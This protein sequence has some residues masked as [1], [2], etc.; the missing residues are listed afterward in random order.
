MQ[1]D[2]E[3]FYNTLTSVVQRE[4]DYGPIPFSS[5]LGIELEETLTCQ[6]TDQ[7]PAITRK[8]SVNKLVCNIR[9]ASGSAPAID[10]LYA[11]LMLGLEGTVE[12]HSDVLQRNAV[13]NRKQRVSSLPRYLCFQF[14]RFF[15]KP[16]PESRDH[17]GVKC[18][19]LRPVSYPE[20]KIG[21]QPIS[22][23]NG[24]P[25]V[26]FYPHCC[27]SSNKFCPFYYLIKMCRALMPMIYAWSRCRISFARTG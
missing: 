15:W 8:E 6:E 21:Q 20:V 2:A 25:Y 14:M 3:E 10:H 23:L 9:G 17:T 13:W 26:L 22:I 18:K 16:T 1:Q 5:L 4:V 27:I 11:G 12:K 7:E 19:I 24:S